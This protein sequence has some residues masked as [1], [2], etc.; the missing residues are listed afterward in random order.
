MLQ[1]NLVAAR[2]KVR[3]FEGFLRAVD[4]AYRQPGLLT[5]D[6]EILR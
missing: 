1:I 5:A 3:V 6:E 4:G 2:N